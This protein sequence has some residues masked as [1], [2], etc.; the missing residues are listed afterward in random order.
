MV[1]QSLTKSPHISPTVLAFESLSSLLFG[2]FLNVPCRRFEFSLAPT[3]CAGSP[4]MGLSLHW[5]FSKLRVSQ[6][7]WGTREHWQNIEGNKG[8]LA[9]FWG[10]GNKIR[11]IT[12][13]KHSER[14]REH[15][16]IGQF[17]K[18]TR[19]PLGD[20]QNCV[21]KISFG[22]RPSFLQFWWTKSIFQ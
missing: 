6:G 18:G 20:P 19:T 22:K 11:K 8:T 12:V 10:Q 17:W 5:E 21:K 2:E 4:R 15:G 9:N 7:F 14:V 16:N 13:R 3:D 1:T